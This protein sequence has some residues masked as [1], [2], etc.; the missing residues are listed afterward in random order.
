MADD[1]D[2]KRGLDISRL[3]LAAGADEVAAA[4]DGVG[5]QQRAVEDALRELHATKVN[6]PHNWSSGI[7]EAMAQFRGDEIHKQMKG[8][9]GGLGSGAAL[10]QAARNIVHQQTVIDGLRLDVRPHIPEPT[11]FPVIK[12]PLLETNERLARMEERFDKLF[13]LAKDSAQ[14]ATSLQASAANFLHKFQV[15]ADKNNDSVNKT[16]S[17]AR[18]SLAVVIVVACAQ[19]AAPLFLPNHETEALRGAVTDLRL[20]IETL[21]ESQVDTTERMIEALTASD[22]QTAAALQEIAKQ[23][24]PPRP[25]AAVEANQ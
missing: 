4:A 1:V 5:A 7:G 13:D 19:I 22:A 15:E 25:S 20:E 2:K 12:N 11:N 8:I 18:W 14:V 9:I 3:G 10:A 21:R 17:V 16:I 6:V 23:F 24:V